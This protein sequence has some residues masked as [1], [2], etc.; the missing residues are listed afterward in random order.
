M[1]SYQVETDVLSA[2]TNGRPIEITSSTSTAAQVLH[3]MTA[4]DTL[5]CVT[6]ELFNKTATAIVVW[7]VVNPNDATVAGDVDDAAIRV[8]AA[9]SR[10]TVVLDAYRVRADNG[11]YTVGIYLDS[12]GDSGNV[13]ATGYITRL[14][15]AQLAY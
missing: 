13:L 15:R 8:T 2:S 12:A 6:V 10:S 9:G 1:T 14:S 5:D 11:T 3:L 4:T 7:V